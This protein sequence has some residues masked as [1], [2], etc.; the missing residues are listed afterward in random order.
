MQKIKFQS[1]NKN[2]NISSKRSIC[3]NSSLIYRN[4]QTFEIKLRLKTKIL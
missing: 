1:I 2:H 4:Q 3:N